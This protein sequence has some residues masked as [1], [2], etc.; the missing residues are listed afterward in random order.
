[1]RASTMLLS[2]RVIGWIGPSVSVRLPGCSGSN[3]DVDASRL[4]RSQV[5]LRAAAAGSVSAV[6]VS[7]CARFPA[8]RFQMA[9]PS[10]SYWVASVCQA[11]A[12]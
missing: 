11:P 1:V 6:V 2:D 3:A 12:P 8:V 5:L 7:A 10:A 9:L 4:V